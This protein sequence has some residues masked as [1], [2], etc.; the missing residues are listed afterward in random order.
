MSSKTWSK[1]NNR[2]II[3]GHTHEDMSVNGA[4]YGYIRNTAGDAQKNNADGHATLMET[5]RYWNTTFKNFNAADC[6]A[7]Q[8][9]NNIWYTH[10]VGADADY[11]K[12]NDGVMRIYNDPG[13]YYN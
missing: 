9:N 1:T 2:F 11:L 7:E 6:L 4:R 13:S 8:D 12:S 3:Y 5:L 10:V